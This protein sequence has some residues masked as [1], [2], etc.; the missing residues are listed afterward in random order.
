VSVRTLGKG[1]VTVTC[2]RDIHFCLLDIRWQSAKS[3]LS[4]R[5]KVFDKKP[6]PSLSRVTLG[7]EFAERFI[8]FAECM[9]HSVNKPYPVLV[10][11]WGRQSLN[12]NCGGALCIGADGPRPGARR[13]ATWNRGLGF[14]PDGPR[15]GAGR[16]ACA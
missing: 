1:F 11:F 8:G 14:L 3:L 2:G 15:P 13:S 5:H 10:P 12:T 7:K 6:L 4:V 16:S 9:K